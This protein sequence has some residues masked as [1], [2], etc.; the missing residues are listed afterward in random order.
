[1]CLISQYYVF[2]VSRSCLLCHPYIQ[3]YN[4]KIFLFTSRKCIPMQWECTLVEVKDH[5]ILT[6]EKLSEGGGE[7]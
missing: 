7:G 1:M 4:L 3:H 5:V 2:K 6:G